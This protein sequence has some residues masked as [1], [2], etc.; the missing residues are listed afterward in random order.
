MKDAVFEELEEILEYENGEKGAKT[1]QDPK[2]IDNNDITE[3]VSP[4]NTTESPNNRDIKSLAS[5]Q[6][7]NMKN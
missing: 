6:V 4:P 2:L 3:R 5:Y 7:I 1:T